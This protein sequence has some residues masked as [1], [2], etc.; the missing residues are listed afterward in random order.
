MIYCADYNELRDYP[1]LK[2][3]WKGHG[4][5]AIPAILLPSTG[6]VIMDENENPIAAGFLY[7]ATETPCSYMEWIVA[8]PEV[9]PIAVYK[10]LNMLISRLVEI[11][12]AGKRI[13]NTS[14]LQKGLVRLY[15]KHG[16]S[17][18]EANM[19]NLVRLGQWA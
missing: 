14:V 9:S 12:D 15:K 5:D 11:A 1:F 16:F 4:W 17:G 19:T 6:V 8:D 7:H 18:E 3:W 2:K 13:L 10:A